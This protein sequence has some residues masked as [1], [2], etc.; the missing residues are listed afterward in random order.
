MFRS[1][2]TNQAEV[3]WYDDAWGRGIKAFETHGGK[4]G[5]LMNAAG[6]YEDAARIAL[7]EIAPRLA[8]TPAGE[9]IVLLACWGGK[10]GAAQRIADA[11]QRPVYGTD[12]IT[13]VPGVSRM[14]RLDVGNLWS[15][16]PMQ[17]ISRYRRLLGAKGPYDFDSTLE[18]AT[19]RMYFPS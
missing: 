11:L 18:P 16:V 10:C 12:K 9:P 14:D 13:Y 17:K 6:Q 5:V 3:V 8:H 15:T 4:N 19:G 2:R 1:P 7:R